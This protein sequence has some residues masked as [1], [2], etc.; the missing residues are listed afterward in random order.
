MAKGE[1]RSS[2]SPK[3]R[4]SSQGGSKLELNTASATVAFYSRLEDQAE[5]FYEELARN[6]KYGKGRETFLAFAR[7]N[8]KHREMVLRVYREVVTDAIETCYSFTGLN[9]S[10]YGVDTELTEDMG[11]SDILGIALKV[12]ENIRKFCIDANERSRSLLAD[13]PQAFE[14]VAKRKASRKLILELLL[15]R[16][17]I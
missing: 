1:T 15:G 6:E 10:D 3:E 14:K 16:T 7:E 8:K 12:E 11:Y 2:S 9:E 13:L 17:T 5:K 4:L